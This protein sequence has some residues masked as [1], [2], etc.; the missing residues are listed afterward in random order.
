MQWDRLGPG[1]LCCSACTL[2]KY[3]LEQQNIDAKKLEGIKNNC[4]HL[5]LGQIMDKKIQK[6]WKSK[7]CLSRAGNKRRGWEAKGEYY[8]CPL[9]ST[10]P[11]GWADHLSHHSSPT[12]GHTLTI[13]PREEPAP[14]LRG[15]SKETCSLF[16]FLCVAGAPIKLCLNFL[17]GLWSISSDRARPRALVGSNNISKE[18]AEMV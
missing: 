8:P 14:R 16:S 11:K 5:Q 3:R 17:S 15:A 18:C 9:H 6:D 13:L 2:E 12:P 7:C 10:L 1:T 4:M